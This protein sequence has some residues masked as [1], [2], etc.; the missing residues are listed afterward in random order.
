MATNMCQSVSRNP[1]AG[2][3]DKTSRQHAPSHDKDT[4]GNEK[5]MRG[6][7]EKRESSRLVGMAEDGLG[8]LLSI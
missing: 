7:L 6:N 1:Q 3:K 2:F 4:T 5:G 8:R